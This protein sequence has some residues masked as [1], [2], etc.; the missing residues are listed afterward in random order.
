MSD[1]HKK[2]MQKSRTE[3]ERR[4]K[5]ADIDRGVV[6]VNTGDGKGKSTA[7]FG[8]AFRAVGYGMKVGIVQFI[9]GK[10]Q[11]G[12]QQTFRHFDEITHVISGGG[13]TWE[14]QDKAKD[15]ESAM[16][17]W[18]IVC[19][20]IEEARND[21]NSYQLLVLDE[22]NIALDIGYVPVESVV[23]AIKNKPEHLSIILT[24]RNVPEKIIEIADTVT[25]MK[26]VKHAFE[27]GV[28]AR[29]GIEF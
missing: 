5:D 24:G 3:H 11:T 7:A 26:P 27:K 13:F 2:K 18:D 25:E 6:I 12:E 20:M 10:W 16:K 8:T 21:E 23:E 28:K 17:G 15:I 1:N 19:G 22:I 14:T 9:K 29:K 4:V